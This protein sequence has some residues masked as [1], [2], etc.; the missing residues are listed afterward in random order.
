MQINPVKWPLH[1][2]GWFNTA[3]GHEAKGKIFQKKLRIGGGRKVEF[4]LKT[5]E[6]NGKNTNMQS[7]Q[8]MKS[9]ES[10]IS[11]T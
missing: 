11:K 5:P 3:H 2:D 9:R 10:T 6:R 1:I 8:K 4:G 7:G